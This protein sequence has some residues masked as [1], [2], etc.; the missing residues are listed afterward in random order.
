MYLK[1]YIYYHDNQTHLKMA[2]C[3]ILNKTCK[4]RKPATAFSFE[5]WISDSNQRPLLPLKL[6]C[7]SD[8]VSCLFHIERCRHSFDSLQTI[9]TIANKCKANPGKIVLL[10]YEILQRQT[11]INA[12]W[13]AHM[14]VISKLG[15][16]S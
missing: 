16:R 7:Q 15:P 12:W 11:Q 13:I 5:L 8:L 14:N 1:Y 9:T 2:V 4:L 6:N 3:E 10:L